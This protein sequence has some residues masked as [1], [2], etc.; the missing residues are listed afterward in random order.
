MQNNKLTTAELEAAA[1]AMQEVDN[2]ALDAEYYAANAAANDW[3]EEA[4][5]YLDN[6]E[7]DDYLSLSDDY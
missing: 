2:L 4:R 3:E 1:L 7:R 5:Q 6:C